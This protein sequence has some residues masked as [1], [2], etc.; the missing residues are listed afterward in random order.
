MDEF[1]KKNFFEKVLMEQNKLEQYYRDLRKYELENNIP[2]KEREY[3]EKWYKFLKVFFTIEMYAT[4]RSVKVHQDFRLNK[5]SQSIYAVTHVGRFDI[6]SSIITRGNS[7]AFVWGD[8]GKLYKSPLKFL[9]DRLGVIFMDTD[10]EYDDTQIGLQTMI[11]YAKH[12]LNLNVNPEGAWCI[13]DGKAVMPLY[14]GTVI[15][16]MESNVPITP[17]AIAF[18]GRKWYVSYGKEMRIEPFFEVAKRENIKEEDYEFAKKQYIKEQTA[19]LRDAMATLKWEL[20]REYSGKKKYVGNI[21][22]DLLYTVKRSSLDDKSHDKFVHS[23]MKDTDNGYGVKEI[24]ATRYKDKNHPEPQEIDKDLEVFIKKH[25]AFF[26]ANNE[27]FVNYINACIN[28]DNILNNL[29]YYRKKQAKI[30]EESLE[31]RLEKY[32]SLKKIKNL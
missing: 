4:F 8:P 9:I 31:V 27:R 19:N 30:E 6:E 3:Y 12:R 5:S 18:Y 10:R 23:I 11:K 1:K 7:A 16:A 24:E 28:I 29:E 14:D 17:V 20:I 13:L 22:D 15:T 2:L 25:P 21:N 26:L 32:K